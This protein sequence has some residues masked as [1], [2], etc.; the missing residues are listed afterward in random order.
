MICHVLYGQDDICFSL[1]SMPACRTAM[2]SFVK[3][4]GTITE[5]ERNIGIQNIIIAKN[6]LV[7][8]SRGRAFVHRAIVQL[9]CKSRHKNGN[10]IK[11]FQ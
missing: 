10:D 4:D 5:D 1:V 8:I 11:L 2:N 6:C 7:A 3:V 9:K